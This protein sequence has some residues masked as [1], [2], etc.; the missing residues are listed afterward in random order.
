MQPNILIVDDTI[1]FGQLVQASL[2]R[3]GLEA[4]YV[5][6]GY[7]ALDYLSQQMPDVMLLDIGM[8]GMNGWAVLDEIKMRYPQATFPVI[9]LT[10]FN[11]PANK[12]VGKFQQQVFRYCTKPTDLRTLANTVLEAAQQQLVPVH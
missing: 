11:D 6:D 12:L 4:D 1:E 8:P 10:A 7:K 2:K 9:V 5:S 3:S